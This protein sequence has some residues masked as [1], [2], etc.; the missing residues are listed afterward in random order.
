MSQSNKATQNL[1][2]FTLH[3]TGS[4]I[5]PVRLFQIYLS[6]LPPCKEELWLKPKKKVRVDDDLWYEKAVVGPHPLENYM[7]IMSERAGLTR[8][9]KNHCIRSTVITQLDGKGF[10]ARHITAVSGHKSEN[11]IKS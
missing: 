4:E 6:K 11:T 7:K 8:M 9:Y 2:F 1:F 3:S 10:E 5:C